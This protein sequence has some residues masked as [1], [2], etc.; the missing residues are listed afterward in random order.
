[1]RFH[2][3]RR[4]PHGSPG[5]AL[6]RE[7]R[8]HRRI[9]R[10]R[11][12]NRA[13]LDA[14]P[15]LPR[16]RPPVSKDGKLLAGEIDFAIDGGAY[17]T[18][19]PVVLSRGT[20]HAPGPYHWPYITVRAKAMATNIPPHGAFRGFGAPQ[21]IF[22]LE[23]HMDKIAKVVGLTPE[24]L[25]RRNFLS[26][27]DR[28]ATGQ[29]LSDPVDMQHLLTRAFEES[30]YHDKREQFDRENPTST[31]K[32]GIGFASFFHGSGFTGSG[33][34]RLNSLVEI[35]LTP[36]GQ[37]RILVSSTEFGQGTNTILCQVAAQTLH[38]P[39]DQI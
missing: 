4:V 25:R 26:T 10:D 31:I 34:R 30:N 28:T 8:R 29:L 39:Y 24:E 12:R 23:R 11:R 18:L 5:A 3:R 14:M 7:Q 36:E 13:R 6:H 33:E 9:L 2:R 16:P 27:G 15:L 17:A 38:L 21:S 35:E 32:R 19:S 20:I 1:R 37:P 22:A